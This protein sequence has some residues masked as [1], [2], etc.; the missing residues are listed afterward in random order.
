MFDDGYGKLKEYSKPN[1]R[2][3]PIGQVLCADLSYRDSYDDCMV[4][5]VLEGTEKRCVDNS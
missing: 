2:V 4:S 5:E 3:C 1:Q